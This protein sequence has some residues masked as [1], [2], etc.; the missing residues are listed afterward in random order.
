MVAGIYSA[1]IVWNASN[2]LPG[3]LVYAL[4]GARGSYYPLIPYAAFLFA[5][6]LLSY[7]FLRFKNEGRERQ[8]IARLALTGVALH[9]VGLVVDALPVQTYASY[10]YWQVS[11]NFLLIKLG[12]IC[13]LISGAWFLEK[14]IPAETPWM[15][16]LTVVGVESLFVYVVHLIGLYGWVVNPSTAL[17]S[18]WH[19]RLGGMSSVGVAVIFCALMTG[20]AWLWNALKVH[21]PVLARGI[22]WWMGIVFVVEFVTRPY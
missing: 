22:N 13:L 14:H 2:R 21:H 3:T 11:P 17:A 4:T 9:L 8:F 12:G 15:K 19:G 16:W 6:A 5:G 1:P 20:G 10:D 18:L 7:E